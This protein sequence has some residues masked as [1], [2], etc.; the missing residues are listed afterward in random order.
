MKKQDKLNKEAA[1]RP[2]ASKE[3][4]F[5]ETKLELLGVEQM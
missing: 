1:K 5:D 3:L 2:I 4:W